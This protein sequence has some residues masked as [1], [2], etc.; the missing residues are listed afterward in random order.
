MVYFPRAIEGIVAQG[1]PVFDP[2]FFGSIIKPYTFLDSVSLGA[3]QKLYWR[4]RSL[5]F[6]VK[7]VS[8]DMLH[9]LRLRDIKIQNPGPSI[10]MRIQK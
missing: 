9:A 4:G 5:S 10:N 6:N 3:R 1:Q 8:T 7:V 2:F